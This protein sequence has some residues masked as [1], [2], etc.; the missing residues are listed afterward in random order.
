MYILGSV[1]AL[2]ALSF[3]GTTE[4]NPPRVEAVPS[5]AAHRLTSPPIIDGKLLDDCWREA[6]VASEFWRSDGSSRANPSA[7]VQLAF[8]DETLFVGFRCPLPDPQS[9]TNQRDQMFGKNTAQVFLDPLLDH[10]RD[11]GLAE[12]P[13]A[14]FY[15]HPGPKIFRFAVNAANGQFSDLM[16]IPWWKVPWQSA[17]HIGDNFWSAE[18][19]IPFA[20]FAFFES[21]DR[22]GLQPGWESTWGINFA[23]DDTAWVRNAESRDATTSLGKFNLNASESHYPTAFGSATAIDVDPTPHRWAY[24]I[25]IGPKTVGEVPIVL[26]MSNHTG[27]HRKIKVIASA[28]SHEDTE[29]ENMFPPQEGIWEV[30]PEGIHWAHGSLSIP[31]HS[32][33]DQ[34]LL[35]SVQDLETGKIVAHRPVLLDGVD[36][37]LAVWDRSFYMN[38]DSANLTIRCHRTIENLGEAQ[39]DLRKAGETEILQS[40]TVPFDSRNTARAAFDLEA[41]PPGNYPVTLTVDG[42]DQAPFATNLRKLPWRAGG[43]QYTERGTLLRDGEPFFPFGMY[44]V[45]NYL[46]GEFREEYADAGFNTYVME[47]M[48]ASSYVT[49]ARGMEPFGLVPIV[50]IQNMSEVYGYESGRDYSWKG[51]REGRLPKAREA[52][53]MISSEVPENILAWYTRDEPNELMY[54]LVKGLHDIVNEEDPYHPS[55]TVIFTPHL[56]PAYHSATDILG[57][58]IYPGFP[59]GRV[60]RVGE[61]MGIAVDDMRGKPVIAVLQTFYE[62]NGGRMP[63]RA[64]LRCMTYHSIVRGVA[65]ILYFSYHFGG[66]MK[67][68]DPQTWEDLKELAGEIRSLA[69]ILLSNPPSDLLLEVDPANSVDARLYSQEG[70][71]HVIAVNYENHP[72][73]AS[74]FKI[75]SRSNSNPRIENVNVLFENRDIQA[76]EGAWKDDFAPYEVHLY[77]IRPK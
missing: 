4:N 43:V 58:D 69:P 38:E 21:T 63:N 18:L 42:Y 57:P 7:S 6:D 35:M 74:S 72:V 33:G 11:V 12:D 16:G 61:A 55:F 14:L 40:R 10:R 50:G 27:V 64:E 65:G 32:P 62:D 13:D 47:W 25:G 37:G 66:P 48:N 76:E 19:A 77:A 45:T 67:E 44:Y 31:I 41:L 23:I 46:S 1:L 53:R 22:S 30:A 52:V 60:G 73:N 15:A 70:V 2:S 36:A 17:T 71:Y 28:V 8:D 34:L 51:M 26:T 59:G 9:V 56:F 29:I 20:S 24:L 39:C 49:M 54:P 68:R 75:Q 3:C 5:I